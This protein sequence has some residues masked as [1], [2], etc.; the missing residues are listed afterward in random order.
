M[1]TAFFLSHTGDLIHVPDNHIGTVIAD[2]ERFGLT[3]TEIENVF[4]EYGE[5][6]G[7]EGQA[8]RE[9]L[10]Q[11]ISQGWI[12][13]RRYRNYWSVTAPSRAPAVQ[14]ILQGWAKT[15]LSGTDGF[16][17]VDRYMPVRISTVQGE[18]SCTIGDIA[19]GTCPW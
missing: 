3:P 9:L 7:I 15:M 19:E 11:I 5:R 14:Q 1:G 4:K 8:R 6:V 17:E 12:R 13:I 2:P 16:K 10:L 18:S